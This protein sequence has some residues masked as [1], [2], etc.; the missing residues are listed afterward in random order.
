M[1]DQ[2][3]GASIDALQSQINMGD[4]RIAEIDQQLASLGPSVGN[5][6]AD[7]WHNLL[8]QERNSI[9]REQ[10]RLGTIIGD[11]AREGRGFEQGK[12]QFNAELAQLRDSYR[13]AVDEL[14]KSVE[15]I[16]RKYAELGKNAEIMKA[17][18]DLSASTRNTQKLGPSRDLEAVV[19]WLERSRGTGS[20]RDSHAAPRR[21]R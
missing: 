14:R 7:N 6:T 21:K 19:R 20:K 5:A 2:N 17:L 18:A 10:R 3:P 12:R 4:A 13:Q 9:G 16:Q 11:L 8:V 15:R 1:G